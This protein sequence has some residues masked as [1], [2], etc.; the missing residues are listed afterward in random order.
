MCFLVLSVTQIYAQSRTVTGTV[1]AQDDG[2]PIPGVTVRV[3]GVQTGTVT[4]SDG[5]FS[6][7]VPS[8]NSTIVFSFVGYNTQNVAL[9][10]KSNLSVV[11]TANSRQLNEVVVTGV[12]TAT[13]KRKVAI[14]VATVSSKDFGK[15]ATTSV[16]Q[17]LVGQIAGAQVQ[18]TSGT[19]GQQALI[20]LRGYTNLGSSQPLIMIDGVQASSDL[21]TYL[22]PATVDHIEVVKGSAGGMLYGAQ[23]GNGV[24]QV[25][26]KKGSNNGKLTID[27]AS[28][29]SI[30]KVLQ[31]HDLVATNHHYVT[32]ASGN[33]LDQNGDI[34]KP[35][36]HGIWQA[37]QEMPFS[38]DPT[39]VNNKPFNLPTYNHV[40]QGYRTAATFTNSINIRGG[41]EKTYY[42]FGASNLS[43]QDVF[44]N[45]YNRTNL[46]LNI[47]FQP[48]KGLTFRNSTNLFYTHEDL[49]SGS[50]FN[51]VNSYQ[52][53]DFNYVDPTTGKLV[54]KPSDN[55]DGNNSLSEK[56]YHQRYNNTPRIVEN[57]NLNYKFP[58]FVELDAK[59]ALD[60]KTIDGYDYYQNQD[61]TYQGVFWGPSKTGSIVDSH[62]N[63]QSQYGIASVYFRTDFQNDF[64]LNIPIRTT[65][66]ASYD[67]RKQDERYYQLQGTGLTPYPPANIVG[68]SQK[69]GYDV[70]YNSLFYGYLVNQ[71]IDYANLVGISGGFRSDYS[72]LFGG[73]SKAFTFPR[74]TIYFNPSELFKTSWLTNWK[75]RGAYGEA[76]VQPYKSDN[77]SDPYTRQLTFGNGSLGTTGASIYNPS[78]ASN[79]NLQ[80]QVTKELEIGT[81]V[82]FTPTQGSW[83]SRVNVSGSY[84][85][86]KSNNDVQQASV[87][88]STGFE[89]VYDNLVSLKG[90]GIDLSLDASVYKASVFTWDIGVRF[91]TSKSFITKISN[92][93]PITSGVFQLKEGQQMGVMYG[94]T[95]L[96]S[97][98]QVNKS[99][100][101]RYIPAANA[102][103]YTL[104]DGNV[105]AIATNRA[106]VTAANDLSVIGNTNPDFTSS[107]INRFT[108]A[109]NLSVS[110]QFDWFKGG[111][112]YNQ[113]RQWLYRDRLSADFDKAVTVNGKT[114][115][116]VNYYDSFYNTLNPISWFVENGSFVRLRDASVSYDLTK[117]IHQKWLRSLV[118]TASGRNLLTFTKYHGLDPESTSAVSSQG[119]SLGS[120]GSF[121]GVDYY[122]VPNVRSY[123]FSLNIGF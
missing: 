13:E 50:R 1:T 10:G 74:G 78:V 40:D 71:T 6:I 102:G 120:V 21:L 67:Y 35:D 98:D 101:Q 111:D 15:S 38:T 77:L 89:S 42:A 105:V 29:V 52:F 12:G 103:Q 53:I 44:S 72:S 65:T 33:I 4:G 66:Q 20:I 28:K 43:Q 90:H 8:E 93:I 81:D 5:K 14:D 37:P 30:D 82:T 47:G 94:Q 109:R 107:L 3:Q 32:D 9:A 83:F 46:N 69:T 31:G 7:K 76:G 88:P 58:K 95:P 55:I 73:Q 62:D 34:L 17:A 110:F 85:N 56:D 92:G 49:L 24:I 116:F 121:R 100:G 115:A 112:I 45:N 118:A 23:G 63:I 113:T 39:V 11:L 79:P 57:A 26:T 27:V 87:A 41:T 51:L 25:F 70:S 108:I 97:I 48:V 96:H 123:Q 114:G 54:V 36:V 59:Y 99:T 104:V 84:W 18:Q 64:H 22:D 19:P 91:A 2:L 106:V 80:V 60:Y 75:V 119:G 16:D 68:A 122:G 117:V 61:N 86:R